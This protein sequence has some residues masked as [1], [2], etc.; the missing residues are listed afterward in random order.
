MTQIFKHTTLKLDDLTYTKPEKQGNHYYSQIYH[1]DNKPVYIQTPLL[2]CGIPG[3]N[4]N[5]KNSLLQLKIDGDDFGIYDFFL[6]LDASTR[7]TQNSLMCVR[8]RNLS[9]YQHGW[10]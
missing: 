9:G 8:I 3:S 2:G 6:K 10:V 5:S 1:G 4:L 7:R